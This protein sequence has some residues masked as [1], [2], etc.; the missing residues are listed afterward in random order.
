MTSRLNPNTMDIG[1]N[2]MEALIHHQRD[3]LG[4]EAFTNQYQDLFFTDAELRRFY[5]VGC[6]VLTQ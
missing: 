3:F 2:R 5:F 1:N 4:A 6:N